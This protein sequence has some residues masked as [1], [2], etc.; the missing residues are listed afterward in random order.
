MSFSI[1]NGDFPQ[2]CTRLPEGKGR[3]AW[4]T[5]VR[6]CCEAVTL[7]T[8]TLGTNV[9]T[10]SGDEWR[11]RTVV[12]RMGP[13]PPF[14]KGKKTK[15]RRIHKLHKSQ[16]PHPLAAFNRVQRFQHVFG[17]CP[18]F[19]FFGTEDNLFGVRCNAKR[20]MQNLQDTT[21]QSRSLEVYIRKRLP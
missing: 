6:Q 15:Q 12:A 4:D 17:P 14:Q 3:V 20:T 9:P 2:L 16:E 11:A 8:R 21:S 1:K 19:N 5:Y 7:D 18:R 10:I 13:L